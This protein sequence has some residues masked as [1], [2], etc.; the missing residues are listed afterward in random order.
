MEIELALDDIE[1]IK[2]ELI[3]LLPDVKSSHRVEAMAR[4]L[5]FDTNAA[6]RAT[7]TSG[8]VVCVASDA[9]FLVYLKNHGFP[10]VTSG[11]LDEALVCAKLSDER[12]SIKAVM[13]KQ[14]TL[15]R[16]GF[17]IARDRT[18]SR[19]QCEA[20]FQEAR[21][22]MLKPHTVGEFIR[23]REFLSQ[24]RK[25]ASIN[26]KLSSYGLK[27]RAEG[28]HRDLRAPDPYV[29]NGLF[30][31][32]AFHLGFLVKP[33][34]MNAYL[35]IGAKHNGEATN[36]AANEA[37]RIAVKQARR[38]AWQNMMTAAINAGLDQNL[39]TLD[40]GDNRWAGKQAFY[41]LTIAGLPAIAAVGDGG[42]GEL[43]FKVAVN[44]SEDAEEWIEPLTAYY[45]RFR[46][47]D[48]FAEG[49]L[50]RKKGKW[51]QTSG[52]PICHF[53]RQLL[54]VI[55]AADVKPNGYL[56]VAP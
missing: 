44:P 32:A 36:A 47:G 24:H 7:L 42:F 25:R 55:A 45:E 9:D 17:G 53:R 20:E 3:R 46:A 51:L 50:E 19:E 11:T 28:F 27:H 34:G 22:D 2:L 54:P 52:G 1:S 29:S 8:P 35:N 5:G 30:I 13:D 31:A 49:W 39:F 48:G 37:P 56:P 33:Y 4:G 41:R 6:L 18:K 12:A 26:R 43:F 14:P 15:A 38:K 16:W 23:A 10:D 40:A 21:A